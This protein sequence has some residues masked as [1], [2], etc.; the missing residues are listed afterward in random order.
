MAVK[1]FIQKMGEKQKER[2]ALFK[3]AEERLKIQ[4][5]L[6]ERQKSANERE[7]ERF[8]NEDREEQIKEE[9]ERVRKRREQDI[10]FNHNPLNVE[11]ITSGTQWEVLKEKN[12]FNNSKNLFSKS[13]FIHKNNPNLLNNNRS[14]SGI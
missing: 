6:E 5:I 2:K 4:K 9:L 12:M 14:P 3:A 7:L 11:N 10:R 8:I 1:E 13:N